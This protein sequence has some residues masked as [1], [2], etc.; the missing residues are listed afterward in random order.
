MLNLFLAAENPNKI[1][2]VAVLI[3]AAIMLAVAVL[4]GLLI[5][6]VNKKFAV[7]VDEREEAVLGCLAGANCGGCGHAG[8]AAL[9]KALVEGSGKIDDCPVTG[10]EGKMKIAE[11]LGV[12]YSAG[13]AER[14]IVF[15]NGGENA[16]TVN[17]FL[18]VGDCTRENMISGGSKQCKAG[19]LG[20]GTCA[21]R[22]PVDAITVVN[23]VAEID[24]SKCI[25]CG[26]CILACPKRIIGKIPESAKVYIACSTKCFGKEVSDACTVGCIGCGICARTCPNGAITMVD[27]HPVIDYSK[28]TACGVC[29]DKCP[30]KVIHRL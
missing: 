10:K 5:M 21:V 2:P 4:F 19:C 7:H 16:K 9:A 12:E 26:A 22:C 23:G 27:K 15:C 18:G 8:C 1:D 3:V 6:L 25:R 14:V 20:K 28:C 13:A 30:K 17:D 11:I 29:V 24:K